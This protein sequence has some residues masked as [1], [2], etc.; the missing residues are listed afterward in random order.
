MHGARPWRRLGST[1]FIEVADTKWR[2]L[3]CP[4]IRSVAIAPA[5]E[6]NGHMP[7][8]R[9]FIGPPYDV[10]PLNPAAGAIVAAA[11]A[12]APAERCPPPHGPGPTADPTGTG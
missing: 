9:R 3:P 12:A 5:E 4:G 8:C 10:S 7:V 6:W 2:N 11:A 1:Y